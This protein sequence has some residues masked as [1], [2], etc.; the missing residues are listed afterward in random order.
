M[1]RDDAPEQPLARARRA[2][3]AG[4]AGGAAAPLTPERAA[5]GLSGW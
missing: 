1:R 5:T 2:E 3:A 4:G